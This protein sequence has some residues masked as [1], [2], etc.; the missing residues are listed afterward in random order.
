MVNKTVCPGQE[1]PSSPSGIRIGTPAIT[2]RKTREKEMQEIAKLID[3]GLKI[4][5]ETNSLA[6]CNDFESFKDVA[7]NNESIKTK[8]EGLKERVEQLAVSLPIPGHYI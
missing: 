8:L 5:L 3:E 1:N 2:A 7:I 4:A 6:K